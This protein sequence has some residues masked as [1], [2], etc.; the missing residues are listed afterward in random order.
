MPA[1]FPL[2]SRHLAARSACKRARLALGLGL[3][4]GL[5]LAF[6][7]VLVARAG[8]SA[9]GRTHD[10]GADAFADRPI[11]LVVPFARGGSTDIIARIIAGPL[12][13]VLG[14][15]VHVENKAGN[16]GMVGA[17]EVARAAPDGYTLGMATVSSTASAPAL[18]RKPP[19]D[20]VADFTPIVNIAE[21]PNVIAVYPGFPAKNY[22]EFLAVLQDQPGHY[23]YATS[24]P[25]SIGHLQMELFKNLTGTLV[26]HMPYRGA[27]PALNDTITGAVPIIFDNLPSALP[28]IRDGRLV[29]IVVAAPQRLPDMPDVPTFAEVG[30]APVNR[31][32]FYGLLGPRGLPPHV[33]ARLHDAVITVLG[34]TGVQK[35]IAQAGA[36]IVGNTPAQFAA[37]IKTESTIYRNVVARQ[38][39]SE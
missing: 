17:T 39:L 21:T 35:R 19:Y 3:A 13:K 14:Q 9:P 29:P 22:P 15:T 38:K 12:G 27:G 5:V 23:S 1:L 36:R 32:A 16:A 34:Q 2:V 31:L 26:T 25:G 7:P 10:A 33:V 6:A 24:G 28:Y 30:L 20:P 8:T 4:C 18:A 37:Q 11:R